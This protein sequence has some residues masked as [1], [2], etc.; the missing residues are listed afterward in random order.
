MKGYRIW[1]PSKGKIEIARDIKFLSTE[2]VK[3]HIIGAIDDHQKPEEDKI[4]TPVI[5][6]DDSD[7]DLQEDVQ[8]DEKN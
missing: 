1:N 8:E 7:E 6:I 2:A 3:L 5:T 4:P